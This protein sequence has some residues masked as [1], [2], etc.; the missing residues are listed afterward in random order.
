MYRVYTE[1]K[2]GKG[3]MILRKKTGIKNVI[4]ISKMRAK[5]MMLNSV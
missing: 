1:R 4:E 2:T 5:Y 3:N